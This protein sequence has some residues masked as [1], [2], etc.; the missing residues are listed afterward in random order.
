MNRQSGTVFTVREL[1]VFCSQISWLLKAAIPLEEGIAAICDNMENPRQKQHLNSIRDTLSENGSFCYALNSSGIFPR[2]M[3]HMIDIGEKTGKLDDVMASLALYYE[4]ED[5]MKTQIKSA[6]T[7]PLILIFMISAVMLVL[8]SKILPIFQQVFEGLSADFSSS[9]IAAVHT[10]ALV[11]KIALAAMLLLAV[12]ILFSFWAIKTE[13]GKRCFL[14]L[15][16]RLP[17]LSKMMDQLDAAQ[18]ASVFSLLLSSG[19][20]LSQSLELLPGILK[21]PSAI[22][23][24]QAVSQAVTN[25][26][27]F[28]PSL[29]Q[30]GL[31]PGIYTSMIRVGESAGNLDNV[32]NQIAETY[33]EEAMGRMN[34]A[35]SLIEPL[36]VGLLSIVIGAI[37][38]S[39]MLP[40]IGIM[41]GIS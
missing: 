27:S 32:M 22:R 34:Q 23:K 38:L 25:G 37:L 8:I 14:S 36:L 4:R 18:F 17:F 13:K 28:S 16:Y 35:V 39:I 21:T 5:Q 2:Y 26:E 29:Q 3:I 41:S 33:Q 1:S 20:D 12:A 6:V 15:S 7:Y 19:Y 9:S 40:L 31:F 30:T 11:G 24:A 10:G